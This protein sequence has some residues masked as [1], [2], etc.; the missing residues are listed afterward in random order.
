M[1]GTASVSC[2]TSVEHAET[3]R[4]FCKMTLMSV[5]MDIDDQ[6]Y[7]HMHNSTSRAVLEQSV[8]QHAAAVSMQGG[9]SQVQSMW[10]MQAL[11]DFHPVLSHRDLKAEN[12]MLSYMGD[13][14]IELKLVD[15]ASSCSIEGMP[16][17]CHA[18]LHY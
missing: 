6:L 4:A 10:C 2:V 12:A 15:W 5:H 8:D 1:V 11:A 14:R 16:T 13:G 3:P 17:P 9:T 18:E 7:L